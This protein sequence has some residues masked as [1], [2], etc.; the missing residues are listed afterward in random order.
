[1]R[2]DPSVDTTPSGSPARLRDRL[3]ERSGFGSAPVPS[4][5]GTFSVIIS[6]AALAIAVADRASLLPVAPT[7]TPAIRQPDLPGG[8]TAATRPADLQ[9]VP[10]L[11]E[12]IPH[13]VFRATPYN[14][15]PLFRLGVYEGQRL[16]FRR[17]DGRWEGDDPLLFIQ[18]ETPAEIDGKKEDVEVADLE[19]QSAETALEILRVELEKDIAAEGIRERNARQQFERLERLHDRTA[20]TQEEL[21]KA[22]NS[23]DLVRTRQEQLSSLLAKKVRGASVRAE[24]AEHRSRR[25]ESD[26]RLADFKREMSWARVPVERGRFEEVVVT[27]VL[28]AMGDVPSAAGKKEVWVEVVDDRTHQVRCFLPAACVAP[29]TTGVKA[30]A[31]QG[32]R[33]YEGEVASIGVVADRESHLIP[34][35]VK[36]RNEDRLLK[37]NTEVVVD[38]GD[39]RVPAR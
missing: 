12:A 20:A 13:N 33:I 19:K 24:L 34:L 6:A 3:P 7:P 38:L 1:M 15:W 27:K 26:L 32:D 28:G 29:L 39:V 25:A 8:R 17:G 36:V 18:F 16:K 9:R 31:R 5:R 30:T 22:R 14:D 4:R 35:I 2:R 21:Q 11:V 10:G 23:L 37:M